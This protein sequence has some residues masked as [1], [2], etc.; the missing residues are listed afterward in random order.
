M[1]SQKTEEISKAARLISA[2]LTRR[3]NRG[4]ER[5]EGRLSEMQFVVPKRQQPFRWMAGDHQPQ[6]MG[7]TKPMLLLLLAEIRQAWQPM[8]FSAVNRQR[9]PGFTK[10][11]AA[12]RLAAIG[13]HRQPLEQG[14]GH[15]GQRRDAQAR[16]SG[17]QG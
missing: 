11:C 15:L 10:S 1:L 16:V 9:W 14:G 5:R 7:I 13:Q 4:I 12:L 6:G 17:H 3:L 2:A 8:N